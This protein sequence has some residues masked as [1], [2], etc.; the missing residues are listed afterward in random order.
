MANNKIGVYMA[1]SEEEYNL[2]ITYMELD[3]TITDIR[4]LGPM[5]SS[6]LL[7]NYMDAWVIVYSSPMETQYKIIK[8]MGQPAIDL[9]KIGKAYLM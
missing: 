7:G 1:L 4:K 6:D 8:L 5:S 2:A 3:D 9:N